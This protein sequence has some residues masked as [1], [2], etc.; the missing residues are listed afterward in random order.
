MQ[1]KKDYFP[2]SRQNTQKSI[3]IQLKYAVYGD[4][5]TRRIIGWIMTRNFFKMY[6]N[7][8]MVDVGFNN[9]PQNLTNLNYCSLFLSRKVS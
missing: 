4:K 6:I 2:G 5:F 7:L 8:L 1:L 3:N 9:N